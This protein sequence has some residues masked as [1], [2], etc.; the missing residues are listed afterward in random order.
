MMSSIFTK[1]NIVRGLFFVATVLIISF[2]LPRTDKFE[3]D[4]SLGKPW[5]YS[6]LTAP[7]DIPIN[8]DSLSVQ[9]EKDSINSNFINIYK[10]DESIAKREIGELSTNLAKI[11]ASTSDLLIITN[12]VAQIYKNGIIDS[13][14]YDDVVTGKQ[15]NLRYIINN[16]V[17]P[18]PTDD[19]LSPK[20]A[21]ALID[22]ILPDWALQE[23]MDN[24]HISDY[25]LPNIVED[26]IIS[27]KLRNELY[28][29]AL[30][31]IGVMQ[32]G[33]RII[34]RGD[35]VTPQLYTMLKTY[36]Q[37][38]ID[39]DQ[40]VKGAHYP[41]V[42]QIV[43]VTILIASLYLFLMLFRWRFFDDLRK[44]SFVMLLLT[45]F[46][47]FAFLVAKNFTYGIYIVPFAAIPIII[48]IFFDSRT[49]L[50]IHITEVFI[51]T[52]VATFPLEFIFLQF[53]AGITAINALKELSKRSELIRCAIF[54]FLAYAVTY[55]ALDIVKEGNIDNINFRIFGYF[56]A[57]AVLLSFTYILIF[58]IEKLF[59][60]ISTVTL[61][62]LSDVN[63]SVL[64][65]LS[66]ECPGTFQHS[67]QVSN[68][69]AEAAH[70]INANVQL[71]RTGALYHDI[72]KISNPAFFTE[73]QH[74][75]NP[76]SALTPEQSAAIVI[77]HVFDGIKK[78]DKAKLPN[79]IKDFI[80]QHHGKGKAKYFYTIAC[81]NNPGVKIDEALYT[82]PG[83]MPQTKETSILMM[84]DATE[85]ASRSLTDH[86]DET[87]KALVD[88]IIDTQIADG[89][90]QDSPLS[91]RD[92]ET[93]KKTFID[94]LRTIYHTRISYPEMK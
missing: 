4:Y 68:L 30:A 62:E 36:Q 20:R 92:V 87:I 28:Q 15:P 64:R 67:L 44:M 76:H 16:V 90:F 13:K 10:H 73:N 42:G 81:N 19:M 94:R 3:Y 59:G 56:A 41:L 24:A 77:N 57:N 11:G 60:F 89:L 39:R 75:V 48:T 91:F 69:A 93:I 80:T 51:C 45:G 38:M 84:A 14:T 21:Y 25:I 37:M 49:A 7:F 27:S 33:E 72:G 74:G 1:K 53:V 8:L 52:L 82:Y 6:L 22:S 32:Q 17:T 54:I 70:R 86:T 65:E 2:F 43:I 9:R 61:V 63:N 47:I 34:D 55:S 29:K 40:S 78:A 12:T 50:F 58:V 71:V 85:A 18:I 31:P 88:K 79:V 83:P 46:T 66:E 5:S 35:I 23:A 26:S